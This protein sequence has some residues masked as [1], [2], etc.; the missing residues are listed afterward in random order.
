MNKPDL[1]FYI[2]QTRLQPYIIFG[3]LKIHNGKLYKDALYMSLLAF[4]DQVCNAFKRTH[5]E[6]IIINENLIEKIAKC[7]ANELGRESNA[8]EYLA[9]GYYFKTWE[10]LSDH[11]LLTFHDFP[12][13]FKEAIKNQ[14]Y[15]E[16]E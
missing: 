14:C 2:P 4:S 15:E 12:E 11:F 8:K 5:K 1:L 16:Q 7:Q 10:E 13:S 6:L 3:V 9:D